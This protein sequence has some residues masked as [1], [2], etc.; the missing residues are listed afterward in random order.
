MHTLSLLVVSPKNQY[1]LSGARCLRTLHR[2][3]SNAQQLSRQL[4][5]ILGRFVGKLPPPPEQAGSESRFVSL[6]KKM[7][8]A[9]S[10]WAVSWEK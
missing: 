10:D 2:L 1:F 6:Q 4:H 8:F 7:G 3:Q 9:S 5:D